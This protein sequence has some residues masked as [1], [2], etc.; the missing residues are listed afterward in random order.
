M[1]STQRGRELMQGARRPLTPP[2]TP[3]KKVRISSIEKIIFD[4][5]NS[6]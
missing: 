4:D 3:P 5:S 2:K 1:K 6:K